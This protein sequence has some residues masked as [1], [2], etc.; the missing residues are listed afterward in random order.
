MRCFKS[1][2]YRYKCKIICGVSKDST[3]SPDWLRGQPI[4]HPVVSGSLFERVMQVEY[5]GECSSPSGAKDTRN[6]SSHYVFMACWLIECRDFGETECEGVH[7]A[8]NRV[9]RRWLSS[10]LLRLTVWYVFTDV[11][12]VLGT[13]VMRTTDRSGEGGSMHFWS[14]G[15]RLPHCTAQQHRKQ[16]SSYSRS[17]EPESHRV[18]RVLWKRI[19]N[20]WVAQTREICW[21]PERLILCRAV[22][23]LAE[24]TISFL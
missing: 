11:S 21:L 13:S 18:E 17:W 23:A 12:E 1:I 5:D 3:T 15:K 2:T 22:F 10:A 4:I 14:V 24:T 8:Y 20:R 6:C 7:F 16:L 19:L 9:E